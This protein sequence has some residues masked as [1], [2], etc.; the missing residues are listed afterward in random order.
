MV[1]LE[2]S[3]YFHFTRIIAKLLLFAEDKFQR[4]AAEIEFMISE[5]PKNPGTFGIMFIRDDVSIYMQAFIFHGGWPLAMRANTKPH[6]HTYT[7]TCA[8]HRARH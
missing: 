5:A 2:L 4:S 8:R 7:Y 1:K 3:L 6:R